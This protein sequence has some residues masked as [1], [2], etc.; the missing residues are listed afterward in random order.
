MMSNGTD[1][2]FQNLEITRLT[3]VISQISS[4]TSKNTTSKRRDCNANKYNISFEIDIGSTISR[5]NYLLIIYQPFFF[6]NDSSVRFLKYK[7]R[8]WNVS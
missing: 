8:N 1:V 4:K 6:F 5:E 3:Y 7:T 2:L